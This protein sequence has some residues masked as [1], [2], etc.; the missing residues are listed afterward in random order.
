MGLSIRE[1]L[2]AEGKAEG[3]AEGIAVGKVESKVESIV[4]ILE[5]KHGKV[6]DKL[7][8]IVQS[9]SDLRILNQWFAFA[10]H[11]SSHKDFLQKI[12]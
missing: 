2:L 1:M 5:T 7:L 12:N 4:E 6:P 11:S 9:Q 8:Q 3:K 10:F